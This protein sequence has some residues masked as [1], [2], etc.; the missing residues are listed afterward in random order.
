MAVLLPGML[1]GGIGDRSTAAAPPS[2]SL[3]AGLSGGRI[4]SLIHFSLVVILTRKMAGSH[5]REPLASDR[6]LRFGWLANRR[7]DTSLKSNQLRPSGA[8]GKSARNAGTGS[9]AIGGRSYPTYL[10][11]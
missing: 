4:R 10:L 3:P 1:R 5:I 2:A 8:P 11:A 6:A 7:L 9:A